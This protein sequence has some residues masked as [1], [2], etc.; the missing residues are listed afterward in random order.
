MEIE[1]PFDEDIVQVTE[2]ANE[3]LKDFPYYTV[4]RF[5]G[6]KFSLRY[7]HFFLLTYTAVGL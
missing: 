6:G 2:Y 5:A 7:L 3:I 1:Q 4:T